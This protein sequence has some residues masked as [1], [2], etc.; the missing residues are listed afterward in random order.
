VVAAITLVLYPL[1]ELDPGVSSGV[2]YVLGVLLVATHCG[3]WL[4]LI[5][6]LASAVALDY[7]HTSPGG[8]FLADD[9]EDLVAIGVLLLTAIVASVIADRARQ[10]ADEAEKRLLLEE[11]LRAR[12]SERARLG[13]VRASRARVLEAAD[14]ERRRVV[15][16]LHDGAQQRLV[17]TVVTLKLTGEPRSTLYRLLGSLQEL[18]LVEPGRR[19]GTYLL[20]L[21]LFRL[22]STVVSRF[23]ERQAALPVMERIHEELGE[24]TF[25]CVR[26]GYDA[27][28]I[29]RID[30]ARVNLLALSL[31]GS[32]PL[33]AGAAARALLAFEPPA[34]WTNTSSTGSPRP[35]LRRRRRRGR[36]CSRSSAQHASAAMRSPMRTSGVGAVGAPIFDHTGAVRAALSFGGMRDVLFADASHAIELVCRGAAEI[37][38]ALGHDGSRSAA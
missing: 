13:A 20:G 27:V 24:T 1:S 5:T 32:L 34:F 26:R 7:F 19:R 28:C 23:D 15:R 29:E 35:S 9:A 4:G 22:G 25:P 18:G 11:E 16:D 2:L 38:R 21:K 17:H 14:R 3:L 30:G 10:R 31:G 6:S 36:R 8:Q 33:H 37:S 12:E